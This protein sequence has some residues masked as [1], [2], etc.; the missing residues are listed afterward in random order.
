MI[1]KIVFFSLVAKQLLPEEFPQVGF[2]YEAIFI[3]G[4]FTVEKISIRGS[5]PGD[6][7]Q[8]E[9]SLNRPDYPTTVQIFQRS[10]N[11]FSLVTIN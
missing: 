9:V 5:F 1:L 4:I 7:F 10:Q 6:I 11:T 2:S 3:A 8:E